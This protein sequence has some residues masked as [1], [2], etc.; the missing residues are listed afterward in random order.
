M[1]QEL[2]SK[3]KQLEN[4]YKEL[5]EKYEIE[6]RGKVSQYGNLEKKLRELLENE[7]C[8]I[9]EIKDLKNERD[10]KCLEHQ[11]IIEREKQIFKQRLLE[12]E[13]KEKN[14]ESKR[15]AMMFEFEKEKAKWALEKDKLITEIDNITEALKKAKRKKD[16]VLKENERLKNDYKSRSRYVHSSTMGPNIV[17][18]VLAARHVELSKQESTKSQ[19]SNYLK[20]PTFNQKYIGDYSTGKLSSQ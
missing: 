4:E 11:S 10:R 16:T 20:S 1:I 6:T 9:D 19:G 13:H 17:N 15:S 14:S 8:L 2:N 5:K 18:G 3:Y 7:Q 12:I